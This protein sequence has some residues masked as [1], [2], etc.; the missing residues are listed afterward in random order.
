M[1]RMSCV[2]G[3]RVDVE[4]GGE[5]VQVGAK[6]SRVQDDAVSVSQSNRQLL[7]SVVS[8]WRFSLSRRLTIGC[9]LSLC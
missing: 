7:P 5:K 1:R 4:A 2:S 8:T 9:A 6:S 3:L